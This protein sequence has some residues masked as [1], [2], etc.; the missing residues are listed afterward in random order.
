MDAAAPTR[1][2]RSACAHCGL[3]VAA[4]KLPDS[5]SVYCCRACR[6]V[7]LII[8]KQQGEGEHNWNLLRLGLGTLLAMNIMMISLLLYS[9]GIEPETTPVFR[10]IL[11]GLATP[12][13]A[14]LLPPFLAGALR[15]CS[16]KKI[17]LDA[18]IACGSLSAFAVSA[19]NALRGSGS[20]YFDTATMLPVLVT[21]GKIIE[22]C[23]KTRAADL[24][25]SLQSLL[26]ASALRLSSAGPVEVTL[27]A[28]RPGDLIRVRPGE[29]IAVD[30]R[31]LE[32]TSSIEE[33]AFTGEFLP[34]ICRPGDSVIAGTINGTG[35]LVVQAERTGAE[36]LLHGIIDMIDAA[37]LKPSHTERIAER[38]ATLFIPALLL[39]AAGSFI[40]WSLLGNLGQ[41]L[42]SALSV[43]VVAC[44]CT[45]GIATPLATSLAIARAARAGIIVRGGSVMERIAAANFFFFDKT[46]TITTGEPVLQEIQ[47]VDQAVG[48]DE[49]LGRL[50][51]LETA[52]GHLLARSVVATA[53]RRGCAVGSVS[54]VQMHHGCGISGAVEWQGVIRQ[55]TAGSE[56]FVRGGIDDTSESEAGSHTV[57]AVAWDGELRGRLLFN[58]AVRPDAQQ[59][60]KALQVL[61][62]SSALLSGDRL[63]AAA[64]AASQTGI[65]RVEAPRTPA[66]K[67]QAVS[68]SMAAGQVVAMVGD[69]I[70]DAPAL[71]AAQIGIAFGAGME[72]ARQAGNV[73]VISGRLMQIPWLI[74]LSRQTGRIIRGNFAWSFGYNAVA[75]GAAAAGLLHPLLAAL[76]MVVSSLTV[77]GN[78]LRITGYPDDEDGAAK[79][80][81]SDTTTSSPLQTVR[82]LR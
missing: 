52:D 25:H 45:M 18:L 62:I 82:P 27:A 80:G 26:P 57:I 39:L 43:L 70:N 9:G 66:Q 65:T 76:A 61:G 44:P 31:V 63:P 72:L 34:R 16:A 19:V 49:L 36:L 10:L 30:G 53:L 24:L 69:G 78:S 51:A 5:D 28:L 64:A 54:Q 40:C 35:S 32:G 17:S 58:D 1:A 15:E 21:L 46:G 37:W 29:R 56:A 75:L 59:C 8:G 77:L 20:I 23:A 14:I 81:G 2:L 4:A 22:A 79:H 6:T 74:G 71:A 7:A 33:A 38:A 73:I 11:L 67:L 12:A 50:A 47:L 60:V 42:M 55:T 41:G 3:T 13:L 48:E 68:D